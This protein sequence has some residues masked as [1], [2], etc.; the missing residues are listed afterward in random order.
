MKKSV[1]FL[2]TLYFSGGLPFFYDFGEG[3][4][5]RICICTDF[6]PLCSHSPIFFTKALTFRPIVL[7]PKEDK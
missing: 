1:F 6:S 3:G 4:S 2:Y 7:W 5:F